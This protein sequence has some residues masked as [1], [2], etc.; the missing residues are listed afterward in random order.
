M[1]SHATRLSS[2]RTLSNVSDIISKNYDDEV[3]NCGNL[4]GDIPLKLNILKV[5]NVNRKIMGYLSI[6]SLSTK[7]DLLKINIG[8][9]INILIITETRIDSS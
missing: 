6:N 3:Y 5:K 2:I 7:F 1:I 4:N 9:N 8:N